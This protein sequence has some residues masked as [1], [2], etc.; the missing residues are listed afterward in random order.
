MLIKLP[1]FIYFQSRVNSEN[2]DEHPWRNNKMYMCRNYDNIIGNFI[3]E[4][5]EVQHFIMHQSKLLFISYIF[6][7]QGK[8]PH[9]QVVSNKVVLTNVWILFSTHLGINNTTS[10][11]KS[12]DFSLGFLTALFQSF[13]LLT[14]FQPFQLFL[15]V[16]KHVMVN[17]HLFLFTVILSIN[18]K[19]CRFCFYLS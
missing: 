19:K 11:S 14:Y 4:I 10:A 17:C 2:G 8:Y 15:Y 13:A 5:F 9:F 18:I 16:N 3:T 7:K 12:S 6:Q 1:N